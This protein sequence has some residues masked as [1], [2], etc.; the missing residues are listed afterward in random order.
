MQELL[1][2]SKGRG[3]GREFKRTAE[4]FFVS[5]ID[6]NGETYLE[7]TSMTNLIHEKTGKDVHTPHKVVPAFY[8]VIIKKQFDY[9]T[10]KMQLVR[11]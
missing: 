10:K 1:Y 3:T 11:D 8:K 6:L 5:E 9:F 4:D 7:V 2:L